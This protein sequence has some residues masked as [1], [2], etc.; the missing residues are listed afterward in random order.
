MKKQEASSK[1]LDEDPALPGPSPEPPAPL[2]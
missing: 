2:A 1:K